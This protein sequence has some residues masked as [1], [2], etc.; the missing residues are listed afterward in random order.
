MLK[1]E[2]NPF[3]FKSAFIIYLFFFSF[4]YFQKFRHYLLTPQHRVCA[5]F[6]SFQ[7]IPLGF[8]INKYINYKNINYNEAFYFYFFIETKVVL[9]S[10]SSQ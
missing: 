6:S 10:V 8:T 9:R 7:Q 1:P 3:A 5:Y 4:I 2:K